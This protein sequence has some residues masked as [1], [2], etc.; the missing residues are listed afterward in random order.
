M[1]NLRLGEGRIRLGIS[2]DWR[3]TEKWL[4]PTVSIFFPNAPEHVP[5]KKK[6]PDIPVLS[7]YS[8]PPDPE[9]W[10]V[11]P[12]APLPTSAT[13]PVLATAIKN[14][15][16]QLSGFMTL[17]QTI[18]AQ[19]LVY[20]LTHGSAAPL[21]HDL[22]QIRVQNSRSVLAFGEEFTDTLAHW[23][24]KGYVVGP[25]PLISLCSTCQREKV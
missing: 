6:C 20:E 19:T 13:S 7:S 1:H 8:L 21:L 15:S 3:D 25:V 5:G 11:F 14:I 9:F 24:R 23:I 22:P 18:R 17:S 10:K 2:A 12:A 4:N 16:E